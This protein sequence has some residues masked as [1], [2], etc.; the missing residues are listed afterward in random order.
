VII[1]K[2]KVST[3]GCDIL[4]IDYDQLMGTHTKIRHTRK[5]MSF[6]ISDYHHSCCRV[7]GMV[8][9]E[10]GSKRYR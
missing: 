10:S 4:T 6:D 7:H 1:T 8:R 5:E 2:L 9:L 3:F